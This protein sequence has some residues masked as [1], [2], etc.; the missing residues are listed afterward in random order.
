MSALKTP[1]TEQQKEAHSLTIHDRML[2]GNL[3]IEEVCA[4]K[5]R[6][7]AGF[8]VD[9]KNGLVSIKKIGRKS[10]VPGPV[11]RAYIAGERL[12]S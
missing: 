12:A 10:V 2:Y 4:L 11:A 7:K 9:L 3:T 6:S 5:S 8:Y 1:T